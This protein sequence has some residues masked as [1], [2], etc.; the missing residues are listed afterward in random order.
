MHRIYFH[1]GLPKTGT[2]FL[3]STFA[4]N[5]S[6]YR[7]AG[8]TYPDLDGTLERA[9]RGEITSGN[10]TRLAAFSLSTIR[11]TFEPLAPDALLE[12]LDTSSDYLI[13]S[14]WLSKCE[15]KFLKLIKYIFSTK[16]QVRFLIFVRNPVDHIHSSYL[17]GLKGGHY[18]QPIDVIIH[19]LIKEERRMLSL[20]NDLADCSSVVN[21]D[22]QRHRLVE[23]FDDIVFQRPISVLPPTQRINLSPNA[24]QAEILRLVS[25]LGASN[26]K[27]ANEYI[28]ASGDAAISEANWQ[29]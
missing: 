4:I 28:E 2:S 3:Q 21:Y 24:H 12:V 7:S 29:T 22:D 13:S 14:E 10:G 26:V 8:L 6:L 27:F 18:S 23:A 15:V 16:F 1:I 25:C 19:D 5:A 20:A 11:P 9:A 17:E